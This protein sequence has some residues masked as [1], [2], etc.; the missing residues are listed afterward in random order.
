MARAVR[1]GRLKESS[2]ASISACFLDVPAWSCS[3]GVVGVAW[4]LR[5]CPGPCRLVD[6]PLLRQASCPRVPPRGFAMTRTSRWPVSPPGR[7]SGTTPCATSMLPSSSTHP[8]PCRSFAQL[9]SGF[10]RTHDCRPAMSPGLGIP[11]TT[12]STAGS[13]CSMYARKRLPFL[14]PQA[15]SA[16]PAWGVEHLQLLGRACKVPEDQLATM[17]ELPTSTPAVDNVDR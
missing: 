6:R 14:L 12:R 13:R 2:Q 3:I 5:A 15:S 7:P 11:L 9:A 16:V 1:L 4:P 8:L 17:A 10:R